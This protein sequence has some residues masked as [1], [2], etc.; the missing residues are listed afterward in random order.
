MPSVR[1]GVSRRHRRTVVMPPFL[2]RKWNAV[3]AWEPLHYSLAFFLRRWHSLTTAPV[4]SCPVPEDT[5]RRL[6]EHNR[7][8]LGEPEILRSI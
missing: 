7:S 1:V 6:Q 8:A 5:G 2:T 4:Y 3:L